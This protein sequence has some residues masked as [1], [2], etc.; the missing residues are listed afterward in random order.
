MA[1]VATKSDLPVANKIASSYGQNMQKEISS[2]N[3][4]N[5]CFTYRETSA[6]DD[7]QSVE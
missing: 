6:R 2:N 7:V 3:E 4:N 1:L 5:V